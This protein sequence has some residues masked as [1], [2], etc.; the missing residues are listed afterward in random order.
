MLAAWRR[1]CARR[2][3]AE[4]SERSG[5]MSVTLVMFDKSG[6]RRD[7]PLKTGPNTIGRK[8]DC[9]IRIPSSEVSRLHA[10]VIA[11]EDGCTIRDLGAA[12]G[13]FLNYQRVTEEDC[14]PGD[15]ITIGPV[16]FTVQVNGE[17]DDEELK[18]IR[19]QLMARS[20]AA[21]GAGPSIRTSEHVLS[22]DDEMDPIAALEALASSADQTSIEPDEDEKL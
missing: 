14:E 7:F 4:F 2:A 20:R 17:P 22:S 10:E 8:T 15:F 1:R 5:S 19:E 13:T 11:D 16:T 9:D 21:A 18:D 3:R 6:T 12:N